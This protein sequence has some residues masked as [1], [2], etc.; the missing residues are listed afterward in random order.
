M[1]IRY[2]S[3]CLKIIRW[4]ERHQKACV[5]CDKPEFLLRHCLS[6]P[7]LK[8]RQA[9]EW[10]LLWWQHTLINMQELALRFLSR[11]EFNHHHRHCMLQINASVLYF[12]L[13]L[14]H[15]L[16]LVWC[17][18]T[19]WLISGSM[20]IRWVDHFARCIRPFILFI[21]S[22][23]YEMQSNSSSMLSAYT[24]THQHNNTCT[25]YDWSVKLP[26]TSRKLRNRETHMHEK[27]ERMKQTRNRMR[28]SFWLQVD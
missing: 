13:L 24:H 19:G 18:L 16:N 6:F 9:Y 12:L 11:L 21:L 2:L 4:A 1:Y 26:N 7:S 10:L 3:G 23:Y 25:R 14:L 5:A 22:I 27:T 17:E 28:F 20:P 8:L 15:R